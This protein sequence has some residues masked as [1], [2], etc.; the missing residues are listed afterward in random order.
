MISL[1]FLVLLNYIIY[2]KKQK[3]LTLDEFGLTE[4][5]V[6]LSRDDKEKGKKDVKH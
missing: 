1:L 5:I 2:A 3:K 4:K 6:T